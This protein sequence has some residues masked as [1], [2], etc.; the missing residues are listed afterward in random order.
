M[1]S[2][3]RVVVAAVVLFAAAASAS[4]IHDDPYTLKNGRVIDPTKPEDVAAAAAA[5]EDRSADVAKP[6]HDSP[7]R[8][9]GR[10]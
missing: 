2:F 1:V 8:G 3:V 6:L 9:F 4:S 7:M 10:R 5:A